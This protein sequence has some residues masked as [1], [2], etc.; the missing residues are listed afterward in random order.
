MSIGQ[1]NVIMSPLYYWTIPMY[2]VP[3]GQSMDSKQA[4]LFTTIYY[5][6]NIYNT[7]LYFQTFWLIQTFTQDLKIADYL[8]I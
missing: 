6:F 5:L 2:K 1:Q 4:L 8:H 7:R 3:R